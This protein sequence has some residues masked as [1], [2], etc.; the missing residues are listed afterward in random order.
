MKTQTNLRLR[1]REGAAVFVLIVLL[2]VVAHTTAPPCGELEQDD[3]EREDVRTVIDG[4]AFGLL[5]R[6]VGH[7]ADDTA[8]R[9]AALYRG[10]TCA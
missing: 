3:T 9:P 1:G 6:H 8:R 2:S 4:S 10:F 5:G 7:G